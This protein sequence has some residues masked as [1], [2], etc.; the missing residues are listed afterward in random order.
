MTF[1]KVL[2]HNLIAHPI[3]GVLWAIAGR[4]GQEGP[5][6]AVLDRT[7]AGSDRSRR[8]EPLGA[9]G[10]SVRN[11][12]RARG[13]I[14]RVVR[15]YRGQPVSEDDVYEWCR[16]APYLL[17]WTG[18]PGGAEVERRSGPVVAS[19]DDLSM[20]PAFVMRVRTVALLVSL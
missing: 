10:A 16:R 15:I 5:M 6:Q 12:S 3:A 20:W 4:R 19:R 7:S 18:A 14:S 2:A 8:G 13:S 17:R 1:F 11:R 9:L